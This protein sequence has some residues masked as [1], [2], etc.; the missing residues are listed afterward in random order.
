VQDIYALGVI[1]Y[2]ALTGGTLLPQ[3]TPNAAEACARDDAQYAWERAVPD[4]VATS[5]IRHVL[6]ACLAR[7]AAHRPSAAA[8]RDAIDGMGRAG[9]G[10]AI[11]RV[12][13][14]GSFTA[15]RTAG[16]RASAKLDTA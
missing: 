14:G 2:E 6:L 7:D 9:G 4:A 3:D 10:A 16:A 11:G 13:M 1:V 8:V 12:A 15:Q 5:G